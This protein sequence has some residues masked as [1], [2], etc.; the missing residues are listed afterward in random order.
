MTLNMTAIR[1]NQPSKRVLSHNG[2]KKA[3]DEKYDIYDRTP[4]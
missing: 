2:M 4:Q 3:M 1:S